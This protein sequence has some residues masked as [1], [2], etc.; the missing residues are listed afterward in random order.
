MRSSPVLQNK[1]VLKPP[2]QGWL[3]GGHTGIEVGDQIRVQLASR[4]VARGFIDFVRADKSTSLA[5]SGKRLVLP[6]ATGTIELV[7]EKCFEF[8]TPRKC[9]RMT[10]YGANQC[11]LVGAI[12]SKPT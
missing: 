5:V 3:G 1:R 9:C 2:V 4:D 10:S 7:A 11:M 12:T 8:L 6:P